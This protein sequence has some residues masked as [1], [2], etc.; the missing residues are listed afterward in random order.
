MTANRSRPEHPLP[1]V[2]L[3]VGL[4][5]VALA[6]LV[7][8]VTG[9]DVHVISFPPLHADWDPR[10]GPGTVPALIIAALATWRAVEMAERASW[11]TLLL[12]SFVAALAW[13]LALA[14]VDGLDGIQ[15][16]LD[17]QYEYLHTAR[18]LADFGDALPGWVARITFA[19]PDHWPVHVAGHPPGATLFFWVLVQIGL[20]SGLSAGLVVTFFAATTP[21]AVLVAMRALGAEPHARRAAPFL[22]FGPA[23][24]WS[25]V[26]ADAVFA[27]V[28]AWGIALLA[29]AA[30][31]PGRTPRVLW[32]VGAGLLLGYVVM[33]SYGV[34]LIGLLA[35]VVLW[36]ARQHEGSWWPLPI[37][38]VVAA[39]V[40]LGFAAYGFNYLHA[41]A[42]LHTRYYEGVASER[43]PAYWMWGD[44]AALVI[45]AGPLMGAGVALVLGR[46]R[47]LLR[48][49]STRVVTALAL[50][51]V[52]MIVVADLS[53]MSRAE[54]ERIWLPFVPWLLVSCALL[55]ERWRRRG[56]AGQVVT[57]LVVQHLLQTGW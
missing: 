52:A 41:F 22:V 3:G 19:L 53:Q 25:A 31:S 44:L 20:G 4:G 24:V 42:A 8:A 49:Q 36:L 40:V 43:P 54:V 39:G 5:L 26:S 51:G 6:M 15:K 7:P 2:G 55:P 35:V 23:A 11:R 48:D 34:P 29:I 46:A 21:L 10:L 32:S 56:L 47:T 57:A 13:L 18:G 12:W 37:S 45:S 14:L 9:W 28:A 33:M 1:R 17:T 16:I 30:T 50:S 27:A 38:A